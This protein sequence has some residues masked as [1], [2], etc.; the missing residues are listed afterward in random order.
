MSASFWEDPYP[1]YHRLRAL[2]PVLWDDSLETWLVTGAEAA[3]AVL[4]SSAVSSDWA[5]LAMAE[6]HPNR[7]EL[8]GFLARWF[9]LADEPEHRRL[10]S[11]VSASFTRRAV[12]QARPS[13]AVA[14]GRLLDG[15]AGPEVE[16]VGQLARPLAIQAVAVLLGFA[17]AS[18]QAALPDLET[19]ASFLA[20]PDQQAEAEAA[21]QA[22][23]RLTAL[24]DPATVRPGSPLAELA[25]SAPAD[26]LPTATLLLFAGQETTIGLLGTSV[27]HGLRSGALA[28]LRAGRVTAE[29]LV[30][31]LLR[32][33]TP[34]PQ[35][36]RVARQ[37]LEVAGERIRAG[38]RLLVS[39][40][41]ANRDP[42]WFDQ[43]D[44][45]SCPRQRPILSFGV[46]VHF[47]LGAPLARA[48]AEELLTGWA[49]RFPDAS[50]PPEGAHWVSD[51]GYRGLAEL[52]VLLGRRP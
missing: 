44:E 48:V 18:C 13:L 43:P 51:R 39:L 34:V 50:L 24:V 19:L 7:A 42:A 35:V 8:D 20:H 37:D 28:D 38:E 47:C 14:V 45:L 49:E 22:L 12:E 41:A 31:E 46:G 25:G 4:R 30:D 2:A 40:A 21:R 27:L 16:V 23:D 10:R 1:V 29:A 3:D 11:Q 32:F 26:Y 36:A 33:D 5:G 6:G 9:M 52:R 17:E 15:L